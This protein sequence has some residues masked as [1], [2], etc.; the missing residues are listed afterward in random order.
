M[1]SVGPLDHRGA[2]RSKGAGLF[3]TLMRAPQPKQRTVPKKIV[4][5][6]EYSCTVPETSTPKTGWYGLGFHMSGLDHPLVQHYT[7]SAHSFI[8]TK[9]YRCLI[10]ELLT[11]YSSNISRQ[12]MFDVSIPGFLRDNQWPKPG[13]RE[14]S[15]GG[16]CCAKYGIMKH[17][18]GPALETIQLDTDDD[19]DSNMMC[20]HLLIILTSSWRAENDHEGGGMVFLQLQRFCLPEQAE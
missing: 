18:R 15:T 17:S 14:L 19:A 11:K 7:R 1:T 9:L 8:D 4:V 16:Y 10:K 6:A 20:E 12:E 5:F 13:I 2:A 3:G